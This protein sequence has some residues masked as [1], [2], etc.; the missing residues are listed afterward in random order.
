MT[1]LNVGVAGALLLGVLAGVAAAAPVTAQQA[2]P[3]QRAAPRHGSAVRPGG[4]AAMCEALTAAD[5]ETHG[6][7]S[8]R[9]TPSTDVQ[10]NGASAY[11][12]YAGMSGAMGGIELDIF[13]PA[14]PD[15]KQ[16]EATANADLSGKLDPAGLA[17][18][19]DSQIGLG[20]RSGGPLFSTITVRRR[21][22]VFA[23]SIP[24]G[25]KAR[26]QLLAL[27]RLVL[28]RTGR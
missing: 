28:Q 10:D 3:A 23:L 6:L 11:C 5:L 19:D 14:G 7:T 20:V 8:E 18:T 16:T 22:L 21:D 2:P 4:G 25:P 1:S 26:E 17:G 15:P 24:A 27:S 12:V 13:Y 9:T